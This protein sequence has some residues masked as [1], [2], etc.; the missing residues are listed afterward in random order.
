MKSLKRRFRRVLVIGLSVLGV[1][2]NGAWAAS[3]SVPPAAEASPDHY[4]V[5]LEN[6]RVRVL[7]MELNPGE[8]DEWHHHPDETVYFEKGGTLK[9]HLPDGTA[10]TNNVPD[11]GVMWHEAWVHRVENIGTTK[12]RAIIVEDITAD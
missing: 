2:L 1:F 3:P 10:A 4:R 5:L 11:S 6:N 12:V 8:I 7:V 9:I